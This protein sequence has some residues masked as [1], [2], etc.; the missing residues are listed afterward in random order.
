M[1]TNSQRKDLVRLRKSLRRRSIREMRRSNFSAKEKKTIPPHGL[2]LQL[3]S[4]LRLL[5]DWESYLR[6]LALSC[7]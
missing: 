4:Q 7:S 3:L 5:E 2:R 1:L 6:L